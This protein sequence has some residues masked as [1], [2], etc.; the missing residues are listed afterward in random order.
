MEEDIKD[1][2]TN[3]FEGEKT[4][5]PIVITMSKLYNMS[6]DKP[7]SFEVAVGLLEVGDFDSDLL[8]EVIDSEIID[9]NVGI[10]LEDLGNEVPPNTLLN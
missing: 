10:K 1:D 8:P 4:E 9:Y 3:L 5:W 2:F 7:V 6:F